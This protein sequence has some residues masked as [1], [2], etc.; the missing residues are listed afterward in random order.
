[1]KRR[2]TLKTLFVGS[3]AA[4]ALVTGCKTEG[5]EKE[6]EAAETLWPHEYGRTPEEIEVDTKLFEAQFFNA[7]EMETIAILVDIILPADEESGSATEAGVPDFI[8][9]MM[10]DYER[11]QLPIRGGLMWLDTES[12]KRFEKEFKYLTNAEQLQIVD[13]IAYPPILKPGEKEKLTQ[14]SAGIKFFTQ[15]RNLTM[16]GFFTSEMGIEALGYQGNRPNVWDG[17]PQEV[18]DKHGLAYEEEWLAKCI[19]Q[20]TRATVAEWDEEGNLIN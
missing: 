11:L 6:I 7:H 1:M 20:D 13:D 8:E 2:D 18:L 10:K 3:I 5:S 14:F 15:L 12:N 16:T 19:N 9:F 17:V 4:G